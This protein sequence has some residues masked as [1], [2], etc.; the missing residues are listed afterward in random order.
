M[1]QLKYKMI[2]EG[3]LNGKLVPLNIVLS[4]LKDVE[5]CGLGCREAMDLVA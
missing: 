2:P 5:A 3:I 1:A 4:D